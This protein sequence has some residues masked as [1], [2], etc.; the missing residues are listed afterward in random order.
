MTTFNEIGDELVVRREA[1][2]R[3]GDHVAAVRTLI[4]R[5]EAGWP[6]LRSWCAWQKIRSE[7]LGMGL[8]V[9][10]CIDDIQAPL[11]L[12]QYLALAGFIGMEF[13]AEWLQPLFPQSPM[14]DIERRPFFRHKQNSFS[15]CEA[16]RDDVGNRLGFPR[17]RWSLQDKIVPGCRR[18]HRC[19]L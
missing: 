10:P 18:H 1:V 7:A 16:V 3:S 9:L 14:H 5:F 8:R 2:D 12:G 11:E 19:E 17:A 15:M 4:E 6:Q 13:Q